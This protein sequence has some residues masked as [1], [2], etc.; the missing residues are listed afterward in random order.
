MNKKSV[1]IGSY[2]FEEYL[3]VVKNFH[4]YPAPGLILGGFMV[5]MAK[6]HIPDNTLYEAVSETS[7]CL[8]DA[9]QILTPCTAGN[10][11]LKVIDLGR[12]ALALFDKYTGEGIRVYVDQAELGP[13]EEIRAWFLK[14][15]K[16]K[17][18]EPDLLRSQFKE[19]GEKIIGMQPVRVRQELLGKVSKGKI[20]TCPECGEAYPLTH[21]TV[22]LG[23]R[24]QNP[25]FFLPDGRHESSG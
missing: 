6:R 17:D 21:G 15:K 1:L 12:Y 20:G 23:C 5:E 11:W 16:K 7:S 25:Y 18:Q 3:E 14:L 13:Y 22:C 4:G 8:P 2:T 24:G 10:G 19:A 9:I